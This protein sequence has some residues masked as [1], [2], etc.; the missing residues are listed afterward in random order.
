MHGARFRILLLQIQES[1][2]DPSRAEDD[3]LLGHRQCQEESAG[4]AVN[5]PD[6][7]QFVET[8]KCMFFCSAALAVRAVHFSGRHH[9]GN[10]H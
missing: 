5:K 10:H 2:R 4:L 6:C 7:L 1:A 8:C 3:I 9:K